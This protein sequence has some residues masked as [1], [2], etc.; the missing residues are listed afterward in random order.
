MGD[1][2]YHHPRRPYQGQVTRHSCVTQPSPSRGE[3]LT[4]L[5][6]LLFCSGTSPGLRTSA[7]FGRRAGKEVENE[8]A[9]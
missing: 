2:Y 6:R 7:M 4:G 9:R 5:A 8:A 1:F 3:A